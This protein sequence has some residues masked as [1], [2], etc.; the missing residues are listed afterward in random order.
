MWFTN[1]YLVYHCQDN[2][3]VITKDDGFFVESVNI[4]Q[5]SIIITS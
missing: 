3:G 1:N 2:K 4:T 5:E